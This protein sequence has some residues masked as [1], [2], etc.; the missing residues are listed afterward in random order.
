MYCLHEFGTAPL[1]GYFYMYPA[2]SNTPRPSRF[3]PLLRRF[4]SVVNK[5]MAQEIINRHA[6]KRVENA[7]PY[8]RT[9]YD[10]HEDYARQQPGHI[11]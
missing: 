2:T 8:H 5:S 1:N 11:E 6:G 4:R 3:F 9:G 10:G 7:M